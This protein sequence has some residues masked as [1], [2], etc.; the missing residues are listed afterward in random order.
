MTRH[1]SI[2]LSTTTAAVLWAAAAHA[3]SVP[4]RVLPEA[5][6][7]GFALETTH[8][9]L[10][11]AESLGLEP[12]AS[13]SSA[14]EGAVDGLEAIRTWNLAGRRPL[15]TGFVRPLPESRQ[16]QFS[17]A[18]LLEPAGLTA[19]GAFLRSGAEHTVWGAQVEVRD[20]HRLRL[21]LDD[22]RLPAGS[23]LWVYGESGDAAGPFGTELLDAEGGLWTPSVVGPRVR[24]EVELAD[25]E[26]GGR[27]RWGFRMERVLEIFRLGPDGTPATLPVTAGVDD[28]CLEDATCFGTNTFPGIADARAA[29]GQMTIISGPFSGVCTGAL[30]N[31]TVAGSDIPYFLT[32][33]HCL[34]TNSEAASLEVI[35]NF[36]TSSCE[37]SIPNPNSLPMSNGS[38][39]LATGVVSDYTLLRLQS[40]PGGRTLLGWNANASAVTNNTRVHRLSH[41]A[42]TDF[43]YPQV[44]TQNRIGPVRFFC[45]TDEDGRNLD[46]TS[47]FL[48]SRA[49][50][51][52]TFGGSSG[53]PLMLDSGQVVG[54]L[55]GACGQD[56]EDGCNDTQNDTLD[57]AFSRTFPFIASFLAPTPNNGDPAPPS[58]TWLTTSAIPGFRFQVRIGGSSGILGRR[59]SDC[60]P[61]TFC[62]SGAI[63]GRSEIFIRI[64]GP[65]PNG[66]LWPTLVKFTTSEVEFW[67][68]QTS[69]GAR[70]YYRLAGA[71]PNVDELPG[72][73]DREGF[74]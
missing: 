40:I 66:F 53:S 15:R 47:K 35:W 48:H 49:T 63:V 65:R 24:I 74:R 36:K 39:L 34:S 1:R 20:A 22:V 29:I 50:T 46:D 21:R 45:G 68:E 60:I 33:N 70:Q 64:V 71:A 61:E 57:G 8:P 31:D 2:L 26:L 38:T 18:L 7:E 41:P 44:Y 3:Q 43:V 67:I 37:G 30:L 13:L 14:R 9:P 62:A 11:L 52:G 54:Q 55:L 4:M 5:A 28:S 58:N 10:R 25:A 42:P 51:G 32:A 72:L 73:F 27:T 16:V 17:A 19:G 59:E 6:P 12:L 23:R 56:P 69:T